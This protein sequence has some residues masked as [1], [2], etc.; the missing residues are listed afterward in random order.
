GR[1]DSVGN[2]LQYRQILRSHPASATEPARAPA[3]RTARRGALR[4]SSGRPGADWAVSCGR[5]LRAAKNGGGD[6]AAVPA[7]VQMAVGGVFRQAEIEPVGL[8]ARA[9]QQVHLFHRRR[10]VE[11]ATALDRGGPSLSGAQEIV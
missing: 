8:V 4:A 10:V 6:R 3:G 9:L 2:L 5:P 7:E 1:A 11:P